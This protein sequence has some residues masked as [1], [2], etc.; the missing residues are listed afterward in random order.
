MSGPMG[1]VTAT[2][3]ATL[4][5]TTA[6]FASTTSDLGRVRDAYYDAR[7]AQTIRLAK[8]VAGAPSATAAEKV[9]A[10]K[11]AAFSEYLLDDTDAARST[12]TLLLG[13]DAGFRVDPMEASPEMVRF[14]STVAPAGPYAAAVG[15][16]AS[17]ATDGNGGDTDPPPRA[18]S[19]AARG[20]RGCGTWVCAIP[21]G[22]GQLGNG[23]YLK[24]SIFGATEIAFLAANIGLYWT[25]RVEFER[26]GYFPDEAAAER[27]H[28]LQHVFLGL[29]VAAAIG[30][31][32]DA[33]LFP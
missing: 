3:V 33:F 4:L 1:T 32:V 25:N 18:E 8:G 29:F 10:L 9:E 30:G 22:V 16:A 2:T 31:V 12:W 15:A 20:T 19:V 28:T 7:Y 23:R 11:F 26:R 17:G 24:A 13:V 6:A 14:F 21:L 5:A 27:R